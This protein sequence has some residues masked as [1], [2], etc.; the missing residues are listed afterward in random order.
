M[1]SFNAN[2]GPGFEL[3]SN[4]SWLAAVLPPSLTCGMLRG[5]R[6]GPGRPHLAGSTPP[7][8]RAFVFLKTLTARIKVRIR[9]KFNPN[10]DGVSFLYGGIIAS[11]ISDVS[12]D[13]TE[14]TLSCTVHRAPSTLQ[15]AHRESAGLYWNHLGM[16]RDPQPNV[17]VASPTSPPPGFNREGQDCLKCE[18]SQSERK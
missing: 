4:G 9:S 12:S 3:W 16:G 8:R 18:M 6:D 2:W 15:S 10:I 11:G 13:V 17:E 7:A 1:I 14:D 5:P